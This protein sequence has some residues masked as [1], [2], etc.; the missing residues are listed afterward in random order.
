MSQVIFDQKFFMDRGLFWTNNFS[1]DHNFFYKLFFLHF[2]FLYFHWPGDRRTQNL[3]TLTQFLDRDILNTEHA[4]VMV[5]NRPECPSMLRMGKCGWGHNGFL[6]ILIKLILSNDIFFQMTLVSS[7]PHL[8]LIKI[9]AILPSSAKL[10]LQ[11]AECEPYS[12]LFSASQPPSQPP[13]R[14]G[15]SCLA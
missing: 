3:C 1:F 9:K 10:Q 14:P 11:L 2:L 12:Q 6:Q 15:K 13:T 8:Y 4:G 5:P 7:I